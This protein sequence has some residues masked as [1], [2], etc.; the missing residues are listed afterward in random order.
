MSLL[1]MQGVW[2]SYR[3]G[4]A[5]SCRPA[6]PVLRNAG[7]R[8]EAGECVALLG[9]T[10]SG[11]STLGRILLGLEAPDTGTVLFNGQP[12]RG[13][14]GRVAPA[15]RRQ[16][17]AVFQDP[18]GAT[19]P[20]FSA[21]EVVAEPLRYYGVTGAAL[22]ARVEEL[23]VS[24]G[25]EVAEL[26][27]LAH[28]FSGGQL[29]RLCIAR[30]LALRPKLVLLD[31]AVSSLDVAT[32]ARVLALLGRLRAETGVAFLFITHDLRL[33]R[34]FAQRCLVMQDGQPLDVADPFTGGS[35]LPALAALR[36]AILP[37]RPR[38]M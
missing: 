15:L 19:S 14:G 30:A 26:G 28:R 13:A 12:M 25:L 36:D 18:H 34:G 35:A 7:L 4:G 1:R 32:Q 16:V 31:E 37:A 24:V 10:G 2:K 27:R 23:V 38:G 29:Q 22:R 21:F 9:P 3:Q 5:F 8:I 33:V 6:L 11:K 17:Q 20:R